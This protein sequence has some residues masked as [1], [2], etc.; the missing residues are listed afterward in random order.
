MGKFNTKRY[1]KN[2]NKNEFQALLTFELF[3][4]S[5]RARELMFHAFM[6]R[7]TSVLIL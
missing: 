6:S 4:P 1:A 3:K 5:D 7:S 2:V